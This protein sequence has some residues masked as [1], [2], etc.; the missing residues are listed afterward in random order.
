ML[1]MDKNIGRQQFAIFLSYCSQKIVALTFHIN[2]LLICVKCQYL[3]SGKKKKKKKI[4]YR[5]NLESGE[6]QE[7]YHSYRIRLYTVKI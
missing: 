7:K 6:G 4:S 5:L 1:S 3:F 2:C